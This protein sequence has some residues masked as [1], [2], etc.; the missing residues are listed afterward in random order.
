MDLSLLEIVGF[1]TVSL[2]LLAKVIGLP[3]QILLNYRR[4][5]TEGVSTKQHIIGFL[6][7]ASWTWYGFLSFD[8]VVGLGQGLGVVVEA[9]IIGQIIAYHKKPQPKMFSADP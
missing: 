1:A 4:K 2:S 5:S 6:A 9:I 3:D 8:W 7:Y